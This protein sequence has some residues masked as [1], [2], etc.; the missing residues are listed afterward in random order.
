M[1]IVWP[2]AATVCISF[3]AIAQ[4]PAGEP[5]EGTAEATL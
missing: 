1:K 3:S 2:I 4:E 5:A